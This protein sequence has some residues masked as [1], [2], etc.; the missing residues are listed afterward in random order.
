MT[1][2]LENAHQYSA[3]LEPPMHLPIVDAL[4]GCR[5]GLCTLL[6]LIVQQSS[7]CPHVKWIVSSRDWPEIEEQL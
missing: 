2:C 1:R 5:I 4:D 6:H 3:K 7:A